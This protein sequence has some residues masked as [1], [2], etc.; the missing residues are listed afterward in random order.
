[1]F[2]KICEYPRILKISILTHIQSAPVRIYYSRQPRFNILVCSIYR[3][4]K[5][6]RRLTYF[7]TQISISSNNMM[8]ILDG[9]IDRTAQPTQPTQPQI[10][11]VCLLL[12]WTS[13]KRARNADVRRKYARIAMELCAKSCGMNIC[14]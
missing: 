1:M 3:S 8:M 4:I 10:Q 13:C 7:T 9:C 6:M 11:F 12:Y 14:V 5:H 2:V